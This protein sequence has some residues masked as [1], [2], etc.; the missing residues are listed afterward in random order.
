[1]L[2]KQESLPARGTGAESSR[3]REARRTALPYDSQSQVL[4]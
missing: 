1:M 2:T 4:Q 3:I